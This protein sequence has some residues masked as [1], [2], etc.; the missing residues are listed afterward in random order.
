MNRLRLTT[1]LAVLLLGAGCAKEPPPRTV[2]EFVDDPLLLEAVLVRCTKNRS[3]SRYDPECINAREA[4]KL[5]EAE[6]E[7][8]RREQL[9][10]QSE[11]KREALRRTQQAAAEARRRVAEAERRRREAEYLAQFGQLPPEGDAEPG[12]M[13]GN[14][15]I[16]VIPEASGD[17]P[18]DDGYAAPPPVA[19][20]NAPLAEAAPMPTG[21]DEQPDAPAASPQ[22][23]PPPD[24]AAAD[25][26]SIREELRRRSEGNGDH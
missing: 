17:V 10:A 19:G 8:K 14:A 2:T 12:D 13:T 18:D 11:R 20:S 22:P 23:E 3:E 6:E 4:V 5:V 26:D 24:E 1:A 9:E 7:A 25:L 15:P 21:T 16:A